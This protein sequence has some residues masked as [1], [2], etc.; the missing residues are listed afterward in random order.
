MLIIQKYGGTSVADAEK[1][2]CVAGRIAQNYLK[3]HDMVVVLSAQGST[4]D[5][6]LEKA[7]GIG[8]NPPGRELDALLSTGEQQSAALMAMALHELGFP[9][10]SL[11]ARQAGI[12]STSEHGCAKIICISP[13]RINAELKKRNIVIITGFQGIDEHGDVT[14]L[15]RGASDTTAIALASALGADLCEIYTDVEGIFTA[16]PRT[17]RNALKYREIDYDDLIELSSMGAS[18]LHSRSVELAK[19]SGVEFSVKSGVLIAEPTRVKAVNG[20]EKKTISG[21]TSDKNI[22]KISINRVKP[23]NV[24]EIM[25]LLAENK[26]FADTIVHL[27]GDEADSLSFSITSENGQRVAEILDKHSL[28]DGQLLVEDKLEKL[29]VIGDGIAYDTNIVAMFYQTLLNESIKIQLLSLSAMKISAL[30]DE[31]II[32]HAISALHIKFTEAGV[33]GPQV[34]AAV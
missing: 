28:F 25:L 15:G 31:N 34:F 5:M 24:P 23:E 18:V 19:K 4:T 9:A 7:K 6:L 30:V 22:C 2:F 10:I 32:E 12:F 27:T 11:N 20:L 14:T 1:V 13:D 8:Q 16:D 17:I 26:I 29:S 3:N 21:I 33:L